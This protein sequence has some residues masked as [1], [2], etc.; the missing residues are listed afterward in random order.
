MISKSKGFRKTAFGFLFLFFFIGLVFASYDYKVNM[1][2]KL[3]KNIFAENEK[4]SGFVELF[5]IEPFPLYDGYI[6]LE[7]VKGKEDSF[8]YPSQFSEIKDGEGTIVY[9]SVIPVALPP[10]SSTK[11]N[12]E[13]LMPANAKKGFYTIDAYFKNARAP[14]VGIA[15]IFGSPKSAEF[16]FL[17]SGKKEMPYLSINYVKTVFNDFAGPV[18]APVMPKEKVSA[19]VVVENFSNSRTRGSVSVS[20]CDWDDTVCASKNRYISTVAKDFEIEAKSVKEIVLELEAPELPGAYAAR[21]ELKGE[22]GELLALYRNRLIVKGGTAKIW[23]LDFKDLSLQK[24]KSS[25]LSILVGPTPDHYT[26]QDFTDFKII[27]EIIADN[28]KIFSAERQVEKLGFYDEF[29]SLDF[30]VLPEK[31]AQEFS[32]CGKVEKDKVA[33]DYYCYEVKPLEVKKVE[34]RRVEVKAWYSNAEEKIFFEV[35]GFDEN[36]NKEELDAKLTLINTDSYDE[37]YS[38][39]L[40]GNSC[41]NEQ[42]TAFEGEYLYIVDDF[43]NK[44]QASG[45]ISVK[46]EEESSC[47]AIGGVECDYECSGSSLD[48][49]GLKCCIGYCNEISGK[50]I[51]EDTKESEDWLFGA[52]LLFGFFLLALGIYFIVKRKNSYE[53]EK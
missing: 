34:N 47:E 43:K 38:A 36:N 31:D 15:H 30:E 23:K 2:V 33:F 32:V 19:D 16:E 24:N 50:V 8:T 45:K 48:F 1:D 49:N 18:G 22:N 41:K 37:I 17:G 3:E 26:Y 6:V 11:K 27:V 52:L 20:L 4:V 14:A 21:I 12:F 9:E 46:R 29:L 5:N 10:S 25:T 42:I 53:G 44:T 40:S 28:E 51:I 13:I 35:C 7:V 39:F